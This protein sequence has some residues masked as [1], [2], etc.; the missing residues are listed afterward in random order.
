MTSEVTVRDNGIVVTRRFGS[1]VAKQRISLTQ[2]S[3]RLDFETEVDWREVESIL[4][5]AFPLAVHAD[6]CACE[7]QFGHVMRPTHVNTSWEAAKFEICAHRFVHV[8]EPG[9]GVAV[10]NDSTYG[11]D[12][13]RDGKVTTIRLSLLRAPRFPDPLTDQG[14]HRFRYALAPGA[15]I[16]DAVREGYRINLPPRVVFGDAAR[17]PLVRID[18]PAVVVEAVKLADD[19]SGDVIVRLYEAL[20]GRA[21]ATLTPSFPIAS[22]SAVDLLERP[23]DEGADLTMDFG[24]FQ[25]RTLRL[26]P[27]QY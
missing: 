17:D 2:G 26:T 9:F 10:V 5:V 22:V 18:N 19:R 25:I 23:L 12:V 21:R 6:R 1:S 8:T 3:T 4:K 27:A 13:R 11:H 20:G 7:I 16:A 14:V 15:E 24:P